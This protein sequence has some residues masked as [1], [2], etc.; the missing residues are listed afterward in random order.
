MLAL[1]LFVLLSMTLTLVGSSV[2][3]LATAAA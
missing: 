2:L 3:I 1:V